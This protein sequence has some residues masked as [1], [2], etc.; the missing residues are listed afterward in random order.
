VGFSPRTPPDTYASSINTCFTTMSPLLDNLAAAFQRLRGGT[1]T[2]INSLD[3]SRQLFTPITPRRWQKLSHFLACPLPPLDTTPAHWLWSSEKWQFPNHWRSV[4]DLAQH[5]AHQYAGRTAVSNSIQI[6]LE[7]WRDAQIFAGVREVLVDCLG[8]DD[9]EVRRE[10]RL[11]E[12][13]G[14]E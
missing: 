14:A 12:D 5:L 6:N 2:I 1:C 8:A 3:L 10:S 13:L 7:T 9:Y 4:A 11:R